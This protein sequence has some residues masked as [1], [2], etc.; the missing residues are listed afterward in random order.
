M[1]FSSCVM[2]KISFEKTS[3][4]EK[5]CGFTETMEAPN[6]LI[7]AQICNEF[8]MG[9]S[10]PKADDKTLILTFLV[11]VFIV[12]VLVSIATPRL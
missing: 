3:G 1:K 12:S 7:H 9:N 8:F 5:S 11:E 10:E 6:D 2:L 4:G